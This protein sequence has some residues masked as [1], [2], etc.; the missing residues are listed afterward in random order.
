[1]ATTAVSFHTGSSVFMMVLVLNFSL[2][3]L[4]SFT[5]TN[6]SLLPA[7]RLGQVTPNR[8]NSYFRFVQP[9]FQ[10]NGVLNVLPGFKLVKQSNWFKSNAFNQSGKRQMSVQPIRCKPTPI[11]MLLAFFPALFIDCIMVVLVRE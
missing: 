2:P 7:K 11:A 5:V 8:P 9:Y 1:M 4:P 3:S 6:G 10:T